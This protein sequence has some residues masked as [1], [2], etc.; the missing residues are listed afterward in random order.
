M[1]QFS[2]SGVTIYDLW[3]KVHIYAPENLYKLSEYYIRNKNG[4]SND[5]FVQKTSR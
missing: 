3:R 2:S 5:M 1:A 4:I